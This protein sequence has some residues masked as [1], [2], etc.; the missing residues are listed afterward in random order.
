MTL[1]D[2]VGEA[3]DICFINRKKPPFKYWLEGVG[4]AER[5]HLGNRS[6]LKSRKTG[7][8]SRCLYK[9]L[10]KEG[11]CLQAVFRKLISTTYKGT[12]PLL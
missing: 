3:T 10:Q 2:L 1:N 6:E 4:E 12:L 5:A 11:T 7:A 9:D 8:Q